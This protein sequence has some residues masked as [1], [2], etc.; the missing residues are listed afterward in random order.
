MNEVH[1]TMSLLAIGAVF[2]VAAVVAVPLAK[3]LGLGA[4]IGYL[5]AG[6]VIGPWG[7]KLIGNVEDILHV[8]EFGVVLLLFLI[9]LELD[10][11]RL[12]QMRMPIF[13]LGSAQ[14]LGCGLLLGLAGLALGWSW[15]TALVAG[16]GL[17]LSSTAIA[18]QVLG[19]RHLLTTSGGRSAFSI[20]LF[21]DIAVIPILAVLPLLGQSGHAANAEPGWL[22]ALKA[23]VAVAIVVVVGRYLTRP[24]F[25]MIAYS[26]I[27]EI[28]TAAALLVVV[29]IA[30]IMQFAGISMA[31]GTFVAGVL[32]ADSEYRHE[33]E[34]DIE[35]FKGLLLGLFFL[36]VG[37]SIDFGR[38]LAEPLI[39]LLSV[40]ALIAIKVGVLWA[41][42]RWGGIPREQRPLFAM[43]LAQGGEFAFV[44]FGAAMALGAMD[45]AIGQR[46]VLA[47]ALSML[48]TPLL[49]VVYDRFLAN[50][51]NPRAETREPDVM[52]EGNPVVVAGFGRFGQIVTRLLYA[53]RIGVTILDHDPEIIDSLSRFGFKVFYGDATRLDLL[54]AA[55]AARAKILVVAIDDQAMSLQ[56]VETAQRH[57]PHLKILARAID[58]PHAAELLNRKV[59]VVE[60]ETFLSALHLGELALRALG[61]GA[62]RAHRT[63]QLFRR[64]N[65]RLLK[66]IAERWQETDM[67][68]R[69]SLQHQARENLLKNLEA[70][71][72]ARKEGQ[73]FGWN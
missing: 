17:A 10:P 72:Q 64:H 54:E 63:A 32:L 28:F 11:R 25:R 12:W 41:I 48:V 45:Q 18:L 55:G 29:L 14:V 51:F 66:T 31:L 35:P 56:L 36:S 2:L 57:F 69:I 21:Q 19:E 37:M 39:L 34:S 59:P 49:V 15:Q 71:A 42:G 3:R 40:V 33:I 43:L 60:R 62:F 1:S 20:L 16:L 5:I 46:L 9:G 53:S 22:A 13:G 23:V 67:D 47:V 68:L 6:I 65:E 70:D 44:L 58:L 24:L 38:L 50:F 7:L 8:A 61:Y 27:R 26:G 30:L 52:D 73:D 4:V